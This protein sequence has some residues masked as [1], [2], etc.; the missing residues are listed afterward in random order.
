ME[1]H[2]T[3]RRISILASPNNHGKDFFP[4]SAPGLSSPAYLSMSRVSRSMEGKAAET[5]KQTRYGS[6]PHQAHRQMQLLPAAEMPVMV[7][8][9]LFPVPGL[10][11]AVV[12][13][14]GALLP[15]AQARP[16]HQ[17][18]VLRGHP[19][20]ASDNEA[21]IMTVSTAGLI[22]SCVTQA[23]GTSH[24]MLMGLQRIKLTG[25][26]QEKPSASP[27]WKRSTR[28]RPAW[29]KSP[30]CATKPCNASRTAPPKPPRPWLRCAS[31]SASAAIRADLRHPHLPLRPPL[32]PPSAPRF[33]SAA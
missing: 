17:P 9:D 3:E 29:M 14:R 7:L 22:R 5:F 16:G 4:H 27:K 25:W 19:P 28:T 31:S 2:L 24:L 8:T 10:F 18:H 21:D 15:D 33:R 23:D 20:A 30:A 32:P 1:P 12:H 26:V 11:S 6:R 13:F